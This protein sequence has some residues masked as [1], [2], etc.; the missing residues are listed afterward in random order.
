MEGNLQGGTAGL[1]AD[2]TGARHG[3]GQDDGR[4]GKWREEDERQREEASCARI[5][6]N[7]VAA[8]RRRG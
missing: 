7:P 6:R 1:S 8:G 3:S 5:R 2:R 4:T